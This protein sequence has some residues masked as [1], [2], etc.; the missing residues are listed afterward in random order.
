LKDD[1]IMERVNETVERKQLEAAVASY[2]YLRGLYFIPLGMVF[3]LAALANW[4]VGPLRH[5]WVFPV[6][7]LVIAA[8]CLLITRYYHENYGRI[9]ASNSQ[10]V[11]GAIAVVVSLVVV[12]GGSTLLRSNADWSLDLA[13]NATAATIAMVMLLSNA[14]YQTLKPHHWIIWGAVLVISLVPVWHGADPS[15]VGLVIAGVALMVTGVFDHR[16]LA[17]TF[18]PVESLNLRDGDAGA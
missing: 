7:V 13:V 6:A 3:I 10:R 14:I 16:L 15:N 1:K 5:L 18:G 8:P 4:E 12:L 17:R 9:S 2:S 11:R